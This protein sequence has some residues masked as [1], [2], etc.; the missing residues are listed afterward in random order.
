[1]GMRAVVVDV[2]ELEIKTVLGVWERIG[3]HIDAGI[4]QARGT[5]R[6]QQCRD[7]LDTVNEVEQAL[8]YKIF[9]GF[10]D[11]DSNSGAQSGH[12]KVGQ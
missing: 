2:S 8:L 6:D 5:D 4:A 12:K 3:R 1:M 7:G 9:A 10:H 11:Y